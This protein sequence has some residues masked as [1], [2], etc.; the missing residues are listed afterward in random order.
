MS[1]EWTQPKHCKDSANRLDRAL[2]CA[3]AAGI[4]FEEIII[5]LIKDYFCSYHRPHRKYIKLMCDEIWELT[6][7]R[8]EGGEKK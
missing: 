2:L 7:K 1:E 4:D 8:M 6:K 3:K 5:P